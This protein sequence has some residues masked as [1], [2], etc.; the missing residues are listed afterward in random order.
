MTYLLILQYLTGPLYLCVSVYLYRLV[1]MT[2]VYS[3]VCT[4]KTVFIS[5][6]TRQQSCQLSMKDP[7]CV[8]SL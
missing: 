7:V 5:V 2:L 6:F 4:I 3:V 1:F 8:D